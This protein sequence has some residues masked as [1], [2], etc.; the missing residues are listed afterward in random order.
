MKILLLANP[1]SSHTIK[2]AHSLALAGLDVIIFGLN[3]SDSKIYA[4]F[5]NI[6]IVAFGMDKFVNSGVEGNFRKL[7]YLK[8]LPSLRQT[9][10]EFNPDVV[11]AHYATSY[12]LL[13]ALCG[14]RPFV[15]S[16]WGADIFTFPNLSFLHRWL[17]R[18]NL[19]RADKVLS[20]SHVM[21]LETNKYTSKSVEVTPFGVNL[22]QFRP[23]PVSSPFTPEDIVIG[24]IKTLEEK[25]GIEY[26]IRAFHQVRRRNEALS[27]KLMI[28]GGGSLEK[29]LQALTEELG[30]TDCTIFTGRVPFDEIPRYHNMLSV[31]VSVSICNSESFGVAILESSACEKPVVV[32]NVG[33]LPEVVEDNVTGIVVPPR[34]VA[35]TANAIERFVMDAELRLSMGRAGRAR[36]QLLYDWDANVMQMIE[37]YESLSS[38]LL[39]SLMIPKSP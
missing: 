13:G 8:A 21:A 5:S 15:L 16:V 33:G 35:A 31:N 36:V 37:I 2:W 30:I 28:V 14:F 34:D 17:V 9:I 24:T 7:N 20:T 27:L 25:Y 6:K 12:G 10:K 4:S 18:F 19:S 11:H 1:A 38:K 29:N 3:S 39:K 32:S 26:L 22:S 23:Y